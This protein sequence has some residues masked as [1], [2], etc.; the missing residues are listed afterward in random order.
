ML[1]FVACFHKRERGGEIAGREGFETIS[2]LSK[3]GGDPLRDRSA[4][5]G[6]QRQRGCDD[7]DDGDR[8]DQPSHGE[9]GGQL[10]SF[11]HLDIQE[12]FQFAVDTVVGGSEI[13]ECDILRLL[14]EFSVRRCPEIHD[15]LIQRPVCVQLR[16]DRIVSFPA[17]LRHDRV[18][19]DGKVFFEKYFILVVL[20]HY[21]GN[22]VRIVIADG[23]P[24]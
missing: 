6:R 3:R 20:L 11:C 14:A 21:S 15:L 22:G 24:E 1:H 19:D 13:L 9:S 8:Q 2:E 16:T 18:F 7:N 23:R 4:D 12:G 17:L 5:L 10:V